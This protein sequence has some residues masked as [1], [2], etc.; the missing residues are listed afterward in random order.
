MK[1][2]NTWITPHQVTLRRD[3]ASQ[4]DIDWFHNKVDINLVSGCWVWIGGKSRTTRKAGN[5]YYGY[6]K[7]MGK[8]QSAHRASWK[9][10]YGEIPIGLN[11]CHKCDNTS[12]CNPEH[13]LLGTD[14]DNVQDK[15]KKGR[16]NLPRG[17]RHHRSKLTEG[18]V[19]EIRE[20]LKSGIGQT[21]I[22]KKYKVS[23]GCIEGVRKG[24]N[25]QWVK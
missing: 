1:M 16:A 15:I 17:S 25:W 6:M 3:L 10:H 14:Q 20:L 23:V 19:R 22:S 4:A 13:L 24:N 5:E 9:L 21:E 8:L 12:C 18:N 11:V 7:F 2:E